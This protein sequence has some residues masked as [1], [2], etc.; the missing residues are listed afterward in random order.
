MQQEVC[1]LPMNTSGGKEMVNGSLWHEIHSRF[2]LKETK[3]SIARSLGLDVRTVR[4]VLKQS[5]PAP[6]HRSS[7]EERLLNLYEE[8][9]R[10][11]LPAVG[12]CAQSVFEELRAAGYTGS[13]DTVR[14][15]VQP[16]REEATREATVRFE[17]PPGRQGQVDWGQCWST[18]AGRSLRVHLFVMTLGYSRRLF[19]RATLDE[20]LPTFISCHEA[21]FEHFGGMTHEYLYDNPKTVVLSRDF[22]GSRI[23]WNPV[24]WDFSS[25]RGFQPRVCRPYRAQTKGKVESGV[26]YVKRFL[27]GKAFDSLDHLNTV[28][29]EW[30]ATVADERIHGTTHRRPSEMFLEEKELLLDHRGQPPYAIQERALRHVA[31]DC[32][33]SFETNRYSVPFRFVGQPVEIQGEADRVLIY[34]DGKLIVTHPR[35]EGRHRCQTDRAHYA[36]IYHRELP[37]IQALRYPHPSFDGEV[38]VRDLGFYESLVEGGAR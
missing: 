21:A 31:K 7:P 33:V 20:K 14:R 10:Q 29:M 34:H 6:Y 27:R 22:E 23:Q 36:G 35:C 28:L 5:E 26:K 18:I 11:R 12:W 3:K 8:H 24:F 13:Y 37:E 1:L 16:L 25:Y 15:F 4:K 2:K 19:A 9:I 30:I 38:Q 17:T 32:L